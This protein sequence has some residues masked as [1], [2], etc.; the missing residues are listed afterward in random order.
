MY[1]ATLT[2]LDGGASL[3]ID[4]VEVES[5]IHGGSRPFLTSFDDDLGDGGFLT[6]GDGLKAC[7]HGV[8][9]LEITP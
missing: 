2:S 1:D 4:G 3:Q 6:G 5:D 9:P 7:F 8:K